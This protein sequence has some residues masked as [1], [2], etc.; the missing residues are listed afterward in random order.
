[1]SLMSGGQTSNTSTITGAETQI[2]NIDTLNAGPP[3]V[4]RRHTVV[5]R[6]T[7]IGWFHVFQDRPIQG[8][9]A[10]AQWCCVKCKQRRGGL[11]ETRP[12]GAPAFVPADV[13]LP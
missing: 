3:G 4:S 13:V 8:A 9:S 5:G 11:P 2:Y 7:R 6:F 10:K 1:M 12:S